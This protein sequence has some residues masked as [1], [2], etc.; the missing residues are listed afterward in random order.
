MEVFLSSAREE[1]GENSQRWAA[2]QRLPTGHRLRR[3]ILTA[4]NGEAKEVD[5][6]SLDEK[7]LK[8]LLDKLLNQDEDNEKFLMKLKDRFVRYVYKLMRN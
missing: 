5:I 8:N 1:V 4:E 7:Q 3:G 6:Q 2:I